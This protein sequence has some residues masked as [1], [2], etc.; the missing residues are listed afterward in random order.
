MA[1]T[2]RPD[3]EMDRA[4][5]EL[6]TRHG[7]SKQAVLRM[8]V[9]EKL[10]REGHAARVKESAQRVAARRRALLDRLADA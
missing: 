10:E 1:M 7:V 8:A 9:L 6:A 4:L 3:E 2:V 5:C